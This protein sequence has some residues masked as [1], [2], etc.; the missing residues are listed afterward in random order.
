MNREALEMFLSWL[1][2]FIAAVLAQLAAGV[3]D[4][5]IL[6]NAGACAVIPVII[7]WLD[8]LDTTYGKGAKK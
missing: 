4:W 6:L 5:R 7:R 1:R 3:F 8:P 2:V